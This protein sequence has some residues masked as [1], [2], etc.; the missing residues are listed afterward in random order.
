MCGVF[1]LLIENS[2]YKC[3]A[4]ILCTLHA[5]TI[6]R[7]MDERICMSS[8]RILA[9]VIRDVMFAQPISPIKLRLNRT[10][11]LL[12]A[13]SGCSVVAVNGSSINGLF[14]HIKWK[15]ILEESVHKTLHTLD[16]LR[17][18]NVIIMTLAINCCSSFLNRSIVSLLSLGSIDALNLSVL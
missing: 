15:S 10:T 1:I 2:M 4:Y 18:S 16:I 12:L 11:K 13:R 6:Q 17:A 9:Y 7:R 3:T 14:H 8:M 5:Q